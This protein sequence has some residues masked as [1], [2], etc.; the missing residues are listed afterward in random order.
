MFRAIA[1]GVMLA[2]ASAAADDWAQRVEAFERNALRERQRQGLD[3]LSQEQWERRFP[4]PQVAVA[5]EQSGVLCP[6]TARSLTLEGTLPLGSMVVAMSDDVVVLNEKLK[7]GAWTGKLMANRH[8]GPQLVN[9]RVLLALSAQHVDVPI[10][11]GC[12]L[13]LGVVADGSLMSLQADFI[14]H[15]QKVTATWTNG[16]ATGTRDY[17]VELAEQRVIFEG[18][19]TQDERRLAEEQGLNPEVHTVERRIEAA[20]A[21]LDACALLPMEKLQACLPGPQAELEQLNRERVGLQGEVE[22]QGAP[23]LG[24]RRFVFDLPTGRGEGHDCAG[25]PGDQRVPASL[26]WAP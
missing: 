7:L 24:C 11:V 22:R 15:R 10:L 26:T 23:A 17:F 12:G 8:A 9:L 20:R 25:R 21:R 3:R 6:G 19:K 14:S 5:A 16:S 4:P 13:T 18:E 1:T 2:S